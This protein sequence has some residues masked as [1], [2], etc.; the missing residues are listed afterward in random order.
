MKQNPAKPNGGTVPSSTAPSISPSENHDKLLTEKEAAPIVGLSVRTLQ[1]K[2]YMGLP[3]DY[4][5]PPG[6]RS[7]RYRLSDLMAYLEQGVQ[8][9]GQGLL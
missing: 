7:I 6:T 1:Q 2:R 4:V 5:R 3:P 9:L 8:H